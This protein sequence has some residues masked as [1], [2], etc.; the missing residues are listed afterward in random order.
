MYIVH[1]TLEDQI[2]TNL[3]SGRWG[4][5]VFGNFETSLVSR[6]LCLKL[7]NTR[8]SKFLFRTEL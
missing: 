7:Q 1:Y 4:A 8:K 5:G 6:F 2:C 3:R